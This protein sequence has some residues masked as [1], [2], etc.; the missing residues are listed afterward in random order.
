MWMNRAVSLI[1]TVTV[2]ST[3]SPGVAG[4]L[5]GGAGAAV[6]RVL[7]GAGVHHVVTAGAE[8]RVVVAATRHDVVTG[9][10]VDEVVALAAPL[11]RAAEYDFVPGASLHLVV[12][13][14]AEDRVLAV[15]TLDLVGTLAHEDG[16]VDPGALGDLDH[17]AALAGADHDLRAG[18]HPVARAVDRDDL[19]ARGRVDGDLHRVVARAGV[20]VGVAVDGD[21]AD[22]VRVGRQRERVLAAPGR[23]R[24]RRW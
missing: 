11:A 3:S 22:P 18:R 17:V 2:C 19:V 6:R 8:E 15:A 10:A 5:V 24:P 13:V 23:S 1:W 16:D 14:A 7:A 4:F 12:A 9:A 21:H 20:D